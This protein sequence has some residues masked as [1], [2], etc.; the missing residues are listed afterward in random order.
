M[1]SVQNFNREMLTLN[2]YC[3]ICVT[4]HL[5]KSTPHEGKF[6]QRQPIHDDTYNYCKR[7]AMPFL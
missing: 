6:T 1:L 3:H 7:E 4:K 2:F 5:S